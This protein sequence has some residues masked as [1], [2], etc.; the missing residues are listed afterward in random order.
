MG[1]LVVWDEAYATGKPQIDNQHK[2]M[3]N[4]INLL[5]AAVKVGKGRS[6]LA[7]TLQNLAEYSVFHFSTEE[8]FM[9]DSSMP[10]EMVKDHLA[11]HNRYIKEVTAFQ[12]KYEEGLAELDWEIVMFLSDWWKEHI[13]DTDMKYRP[14]L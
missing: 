2:T 12:R 7:F 5:D 6:V 10:E 13:R 14:Y 9:K 8:G 1:T 3:I 11:E 4:T